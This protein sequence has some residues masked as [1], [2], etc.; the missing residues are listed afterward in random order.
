[1]DFSRYMLPKLETMSGSEEGSTYIVIAKNK[2][3]RLGIR[4]FLVPMK[5]KDSIWVS[6]GF[7]L[8]AEG[9]G[10]SVN[11]E[12]AKESFGDFPFKESKN[13]SSVVGLTPLVALPCSPNEVYNHYESFKGQLEINILKHIKEKALSANAI[14]VLEDDLIIDSLR[15]SIQDVIPQMPV[16]VNETPDILWI[17]Q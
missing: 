6:L 10:F 1:M 17:N 11:S 7:R 8:R 13:H 16:V 12:M 4:V 5:I 9:A 15:E 2:A 3:V 14:F